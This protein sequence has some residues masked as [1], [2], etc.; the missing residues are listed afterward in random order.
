VGGVW[1][2]LFWP[3]RVW[4]DGAESVVL[5]FRVPL[6][7][8]AQSPGTCELVVGRFCMGMIDPVARWELEPAG[9]CRN[10]SF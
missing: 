6:E 1:D 2:G 7:F 10:G 3:D 5:L 4:P 8:A 9:L